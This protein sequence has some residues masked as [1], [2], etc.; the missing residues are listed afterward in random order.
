MV[1]APTEKQLN[2]S[3]IDSL[4]TDHG[5][6]VEKDY[7]R[8]ENRQKQLEALKTMSAEE[9]AYITGANVGDS[10]AARAAAA[11]NVAKGIVKLHEQDMLEMKAL[12][13][14]NGLADTSPEYSALKVMT[15]GH[16]RDEIARHLAEKQ[17]K[18]LYASQ[19]ERIL[20]SDRLQTAYTT[21]I[22]AST[23]KFKS[24]F[25]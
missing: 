10:E 15:G 9:L 24:L 21:T 3:N 19:V 12:F 13:Y 18:K 11:Q 22:K 5:R 20:Q 25:G 1:R 8:L 23:D 4:L 6:S 2:E 7:Y 14:L 16:N 17:L